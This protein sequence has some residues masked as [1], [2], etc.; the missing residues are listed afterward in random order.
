MLKLTKVRV[1]SKLYFLR[2][3]ALRLGPEGGTNGGGGGGCLLRNY[4]YLLLQHF[5]YTYMYVLDNG[6]GTIVI[7]I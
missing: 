4:L 1:L 3:A 6:K 5:L 7:M 2:F